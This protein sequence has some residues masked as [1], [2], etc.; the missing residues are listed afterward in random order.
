MKNNMK[1]KNTPVLFTVI[2]MFFTASL[3]G[4]NVYASA[5]GN[6]Q[7]YNAIL[8]GIENHENS[9]DLTSYNLTLADR[10]DLN[11]IYFLIENENWDTWYVKTSY[12]Y[13]YNQDGK[14]TEIRPSYIY[15]ADTVNVQRD[16][17]NAAAENIAA[18]VNSFGKES[19]ADKAKILYD[20]FCSNYTYSYD[21]GYNDIYSLFVKKEGRC[22]SM[23]Q[24]YKAVCDKLNIPC[25]LVIS[26]NKRHEWAEVF[27][28]SEWYVIDIAAQEN[29]SEIF[30]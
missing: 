22:M 19:S 25:R 13:S 20:Y 28:N 27:I 12:E 11:D 14:L 18:Y 5:E 7:L 6:T 4:S 17:V 15:D 3:C 23:S 1:L 16:E 30:K 10:K 24:G 9:I 2:C 26:D 21:N 29:T 8:N